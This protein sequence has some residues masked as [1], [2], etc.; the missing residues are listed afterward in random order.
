[1]F[2]CQKINFGVRGYGVCGVW[3]PPL[4]SKNPDETELDEALQN[5]V[6]TASVA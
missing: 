4:S 6:R 1:M 5:V 2:Q 3:S